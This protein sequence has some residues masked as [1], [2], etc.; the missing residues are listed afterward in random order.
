MKGF[1][2]SNNIYNI[3]KSARGG[4]P[5]HVRPREHVPL[6]QHLSS[7]CVHIPTGRAT[8]RARS[9]KYL[10][11]N[12]ECHSPGIETLLVDGGQGTAWNGCTVLPANDG[13]RELRVV[14]D[15][16]CGSKSLGRDVARR[17]GVEVRIGFGVDS[18]LGYY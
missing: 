3:K 9:C 6:S 1:S 10:T 4:N 12:L 14:F 2:L 13:L 5:L 11:L 8:W 18:R 16:G 15:L 7:A 17:G